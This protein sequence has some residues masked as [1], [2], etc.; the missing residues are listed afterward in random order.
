MKKYVRASRSNNP[1]KLIQS[2]REGKPFR[3]SS[4]DKAKLSGSVKEYY[5]KEY[6]EDDLGEDLKDI[7]FAKLLAD[8]N[9]G[10]SPYD[11]FGVGDS[12][13]RERI[14]EEL[15]ELLGVEYDVIYYLWLYRD[16]GLK[17]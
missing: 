15:S 6:P 5:L 13:I 3:V 17:K 1:D 16:K 9:K 14:F 8:M 7:T 11:S 4:E 10:I 2:V 12:I